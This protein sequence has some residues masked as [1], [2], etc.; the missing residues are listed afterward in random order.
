M[1]RNIKAS[2]IPAVNTGN[3]QQEGPEA[4]SENLQQGGPEANSVNQ[5]EESS[6]I[7]LLEPI[8]SRFTYDLSIIHIDTIA[9]LWT[10]LLSVR[11]EWV[12]SNKRTAFL[13]EQLDVETT[14]I[15]LIHSKLNQSKQN[16]E[17]LE[18]ELDTAGNKWFSSETA[19]RVTEF[20]KFIHLIPLAYFQRI[21][22][23]F[24]EQYTNPLLGLWLLRY[25]I[26]TT[27]HQIDR[28]WATC[29]L[30]LAILQGNCISYDTDDTNTREKRVKN[31]SDPRSA[32][33]VMTNVFC[34]E[35]RDSSEDYR[36]EFLSKHVLDKYSKQAL[37]YIRKHR[38][39]REEQ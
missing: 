13:E 14:E 28:E 12:D 30:S 7:K 8:L 35:V 11:V 38:I 33:K 6:L 34:Q 15:E 31:F 4:N 17:S 29:F 3:L 18:K 27:T 16:T 20:L 26:Q 19:F 10:E 36:K 9:R 37:K 25:I 39:Q 32:N 24:D 21:G 1:L 5:Q 2:I 22:C 23:L